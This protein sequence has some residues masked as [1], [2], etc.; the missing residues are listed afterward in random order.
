MPKKKQVVEFTQSNVMIAL[1]VYFQK[2]K[3]KAYCT[4]FATVNCA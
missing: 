2:S 3:Y 4:K 1:K